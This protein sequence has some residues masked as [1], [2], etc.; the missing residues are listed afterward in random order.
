MKKKTRVTEYKNDKRKFLSRFLSFFSRPFAQGRRKVWKSGR[1]GQV[2]SNP[3]YLKGKSFDSIPAKIWV[4][5]NCTPATPSS[6]GSAAWNFSG[7]VRKR[8]KSKVQPDLYQE[9]GKYFSNWN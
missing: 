4:V 6:D 5:N 7:L 3:R 1:S 8:L 2:Y 9:K